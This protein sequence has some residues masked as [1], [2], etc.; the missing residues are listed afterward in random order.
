[1]CCTRTAF[2]CVGVCMQCEWNTCLFCNFRNKRCASMP[3]RPCVHG[4]CL[5]VPVNAKLRKIV[6]TFLCAHIVLVAQHSVRISIIINS[7]QQQYLPSKIASLSTQRRTHYMR[8]NSQCSISHHF[9]Y[10]R[11]ARVLFFLG[12]VVRDAECLKN[13]MEIAIIM[14]NNNNNNNNSSTL[15]YIY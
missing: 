2:Y 11:C 4:I 3:K 10:M 6:A 12:R 9:L 14:C 8:Y 13:M 7:N 5:Y 1:M 15:I